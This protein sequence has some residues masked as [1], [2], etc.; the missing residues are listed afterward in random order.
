[1][2]NFV[3]MFHNNI[4][5]RNFMNKIKEIWLAGGCFWG[6]DEYFLQS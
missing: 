2:A 1:M 4:R 6:V 5:K 3:L